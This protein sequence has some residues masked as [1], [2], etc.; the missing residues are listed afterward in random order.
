MSFCRASILLWKHITDI[1]LFNFKVN[2]KTMNLLPMDY[3]LI[4]VLKIYLFN[5]KIK[6]HLNQTAIPNQIKKMYK[7]FFGLL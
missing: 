7:V 1:Y 4:Y 5:Q 3:L 6:M 2:H